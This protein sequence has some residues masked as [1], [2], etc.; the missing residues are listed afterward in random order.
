[1]Q[2]QVRPSSPSIRDASN[3]RDYVIEHGTFDR[4]QNAKIF[5][6]D[7]MHPRHKMFLRIADEYGLRSKAICESGSSARVASVVVPSSTS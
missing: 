2:H 1:M 5:D 3:L 4:D 6:T 7:Y